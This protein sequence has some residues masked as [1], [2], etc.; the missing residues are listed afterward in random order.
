M[1][2]AVK[3]ADI[4]KRLGVSTVTVSKALSGQKGVSEELRKKIVQLADEMG[5]V[6]IRTPEKERKS[7]TIGVV[8]AERYLQENQSFYW[9]LYQEIAQ[10]S[11]TRNCFT[12]L[13]VISYEAEKADELPKIITEEKV[14]GI[15]VMGAFK[16]E[17]ANCLVK[18]ITIPMINLDTTSAG[19]ACDAVVSNNLMG[20]Y[21]MTNYLFELGHKKIGFVGTRLS[22]S[23]IDDRF[24]GYLKSLMEH[25]ITWKEEWVIDDRDREYG[26]IDYASKFQLPA[27]MPTAFFCNCDLSASLLIRKLAEA[28]YSVPGDVSV[29]GFDNYVADQF[30]E[31]GITT[32]EINT[33]E[34]AR[35][36]VHIL[37]HKLENS[38]YTTGM[39]LLAGNF[40]ERESARQVG[41][42][43]PF[44]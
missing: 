28:G 26:K 12:M 2:K 10:R 19:E 36:A 22:T 11:I 6:K 37:T 4:G 20:G 29:V 7:Y 43:V 13:E 42:E 5:Y 33:K 17:Y 31:I 27:D 32:Y 38:N 35:R 39:F 25:G 34:M 21:K 9:Q 40:I 41:P 15:I 30:G 8:V 18:K 24:L 23:S 1:A 3:L 14:E 16:A 44:V